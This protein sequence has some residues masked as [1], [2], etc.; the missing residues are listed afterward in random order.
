MEYRERIARLIWQGVRSGAANEGRILFTWERSGEFVRNH[1]LAIA[2]ELI[3]ARVIAP[4]REEEPN[5]EPEPE[6][7]MTKWKV[8]HDDNGQ[9]ITITRDQIHAIVEAIAVVNWVR[10][11]AGYEQLHEGAGLL[12]NATKSRLLGRM[13]IYGMPPYDEVPEVFE[14]G[15]RVYPDGKFDS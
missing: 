4:E 6:P 2:D 15:A 11:D 12:T 9:P 10:R 14:F 7:A 8:L 1:Y 3:E 13:L 5:P